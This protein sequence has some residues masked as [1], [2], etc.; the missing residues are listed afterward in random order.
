M[1]HCMSSS[2]SAVTVTVRSAGPA[3]VALL[4]RLAALDS[5]PSPP[6]LPALVAERAGVAL[7]ARSLRDGRE[8][9]D[10]FAPTA[11]LRALLRAR[12]AQLD[13][14]ARADRRVPHRRPRALR[15]RPA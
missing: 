1:L 11:D 2:S 4:R 3:D 12:A 7:A 14:R 5:A 9:A 15:A 6:E 8:V 13:E 10:P